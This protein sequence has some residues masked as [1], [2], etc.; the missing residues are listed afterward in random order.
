M[1]L[2]L[3]TACFLSFQVRWIVAQYHFKHFVIVNLKKSIFL[4]RE[5]YCSSFCFAGLIK[6]SIKATYLF[7]RTGKTF[8]RFASCSLEVFGSLL[9]V[10]SLGSDCYGLHSDWYTL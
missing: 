6:D 1:T 2:C 10:H 3:G 9:S 7:H 5:I 8:C 4:F